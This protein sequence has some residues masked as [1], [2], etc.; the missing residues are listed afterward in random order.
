MVDSQSWPN[1]WGPSTPTHLY[2]ENQVAS[3]CGLHCLN[4]LLQGPCFDEFDLAQIA[5][6]LDTAERALMLRSGAD[7]EDYQRFLREE[8]GNVLSKALEVWG[9]SCENLAS[10]ECRESAAHPERESAFICNLQE[11]WF[12]VRRVGADWWDFNSLLQA[13]RPLSHFYLAAFLDSLR[14]QGYSIFAVRGP[15]PQPMPRD[16]AQPG[17]AGS[18]FTP[19]QARAASQGA[20]DARQA[21]YLNAAAEGVMSKAS[22]GG[23]LVALRTRL[24][25][26]AIAAGAPGDEDDDLA[27]AIAASLA[28]AGDGE[29]AAA[30]AP[31]GEDAD[32]ELARAI[33]ASM[34]DSAAWQG[35]AARRNPGVVVIKDPGPEPAKGPGVVDLAIRFAADGSRIMRRFRTNQ[36][37]QDVLEFLAW[38]G[39]AVASVRL[40]RSQ[41]R[42]ALQL[43]RTLAEAGI[44]NMETL[45]VETEEQ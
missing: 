3:L 7:S 14:G 13:P 43:H 19:E 6:K 38:G 34:G 31:S 30:E 40:V 1:A 44:S 21:G 29:V 16:D 23:T 26:A 11:H 18:W 10:E 33:A 9:L 2:F 39:H 22:A 37:L 25:P 35:A 20:Q 41:P 5:H 42:E 36:R 12:A 27:A 8:S 24:R 17:A 45:V 15:L 28:D 32:L 4:T